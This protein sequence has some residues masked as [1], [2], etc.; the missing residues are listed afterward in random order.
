MKLRIPLMLSALLVTAAAAGEPQG[1]DLPMGKNATAYDAARRIFQGADKDK[2]GR[3]TLKRDKL[4]RMPGTA[5]TRADLPEGTRLE[6][7]STVTIRSQ[8]KRFTVLLW[9]GTRPEDSGGGGFAE[10]IAVLAVFPEGSAEPTDVAELKTDR[11]TFFGQPQLLNLGDEDAFTLINSHLNAGQEYLGTSLFHLRE[12]RLRRI[13]DI[14]TLSATLGC[15]NAFREDLRW[16][17][18][19]DGGRPPRIIA[20]VDLVHN[21]KQ[22]DEDCGRKL[23]P[24]TEQFQD[25]YRWDASKSQYLH[26]KGD[27]A[28]LHKWNESQM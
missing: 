3:F 19:P 27:S 20:S 16:R 10:G 9:N 15:D 24:R 1:W 4:L 17:T 5:K 14:L 6:Q 25:S 18:E 12:G 2:E 28:R 8:G 11:E 13:A 7:P 23:S 22:E 26:E 21:P